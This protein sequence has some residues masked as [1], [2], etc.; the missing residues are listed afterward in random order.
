MT[1]L[2][3]EQCQYTVQKFAYAVPLFDA[4]ANETAGVSA[5]MR[6]LQCDDRAV[7]QN[8]RNR[9]GCCGVSGVQI[10]GNQQM[11]L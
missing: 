1:M 4:W 10:L 7:S 9:S 2:I 3:F 6:S 11:A 5:S 8:M